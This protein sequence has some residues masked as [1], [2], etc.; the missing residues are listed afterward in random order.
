MGIQLASKL[1]KEKRKYGV[2]AI[3]GLKKR[4]IVS[5]AFFEIIIAISIAN[6]ISILIFL[7]AVYSGF[8]INLMNPMVLG[9]IAVIEIIIIILNYLYVLRTIS[10]NDLSTLIKIKE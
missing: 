4:D 3:L 5:N 6:V 8:E 10:K 2:Y 9:S 7:I 1:N